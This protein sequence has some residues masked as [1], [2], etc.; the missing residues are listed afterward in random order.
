MES[1]LVRGLSG[2]KNLE[3]I[4]PVFG[5]KNS[6]LKAQASSLLFEGEVLLKNLPLIEDVIRMN[7]LLEDLGLKIEKTGKKSLLFR[8]PKS[9]KTDINKNI[10]KSLRS[11]VVLTGPILAREGRVSFPYPG[12]CVIGKRP[13]D[14]FLSSFKKMGAKI[15]NRGGAYFLEAKRLHGTE[16]FFKVPS[17]TA[18]ETMMMTAVLIKGKT[19]LYNC[20]CEPEIVCLADFLNAS[21]AEIKGAGTHT[22][23]IC[24]KGRLLKKGVFN[25][26][27]DRIE[28]GSFAIISALCGKNLKITGCD[29]SHLGAVFHA[30]EKTGVKIKKEKN[31]ISVGKKTELKAT[32]IKTN[33][34]PGFP[35]DLQAP[36][37]VLLTQARGK[38]LIFETVFEGRLNYSL[39]LER[40]GA[41]IIVCDPHR[42]IVT[43]PTMLRGREMES[44]DLRAGLAFLI[45]TL[46]A[47]GN[48]IVHNAYNIDRGYEKIEDRL[49]AVGAE[50]KRI[51]K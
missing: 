11:S 6:A 30:L 14:V 35:T 33:E 19:V 4:L 31:Y 41:D 36:F 29:P 5:A 3:G 43:G 46:V 1:F 34:Y 37:S 10:A 38:S 24:G 40:M 22:I 2:R 23:V 28:A 39:D 8:A 42:A 9:I 7:N 44:P 15:S 20:A 27:S 48:S 47:N 17:V 26:P 49:N 25:T 13:V 21:G 50:I 32:D 16:I 18:T 51:K 45:A 12:G